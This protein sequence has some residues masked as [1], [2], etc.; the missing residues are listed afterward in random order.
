MRKRFLIAA[1]AIVFVLVTTPC[2]AQ[3]VSEG[4]G[5]GHWCDPAGTWWGQN[6]TFQLEFLVTITPTGF[7]RYSAVAEG[8]NGFPPWETAT[9]WR[10][11]LRRSGHRTFEWTQLK[12]AGPGQVSAEGYPDIAGAHGEMEFVD[13]D[14]FEVT[15]DLL[16]IYAWGQT[17]FVDPPAIP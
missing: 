16:A 4:S 7:G 5:R 3:D 13:C 14:H 17:P 11:E 1:T 6:E 9:A 15:F 8:V 2:L 10:G 12:F